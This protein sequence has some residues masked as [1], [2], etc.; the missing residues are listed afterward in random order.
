MNADTLIESPPHSCLF[1]PRM[2]R[3]STLVHV[4]QSGRKKHMYMRCPI[5]WTANHSTGFFHE[6]WARFGKKSTC[7]S[8]QTKCSKIVPNQETQNIEGRFFWI[9]NFFSR[10]WYFLC[11][12]V[13]RIQHRRSKKCLFLFEWNNTKV[14]H[15]NKTFLLLIIVCYSTFFASPLLL[16]WSG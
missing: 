5:D 12:R 13:K 8:V 7:H 14:E 4:L 1:G 2:L 16:S 9:D 3:N 10:N 15:W 6:F 11:G